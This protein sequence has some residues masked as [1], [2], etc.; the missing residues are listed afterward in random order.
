MYIRDSHGIIYPYICPDVIRTIVK[1]CEY[2]EEE[3]V[4]SF[5]DDKSILDEL[6]EL[7]T[8]MV[9][10]LLS[11]YKDKPSFYKLIKKELI[12]RGEY[13]NKIYKLRKEIVEIELEKGDRNDKYQRRRKIK[14]KES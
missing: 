10:E 5:C 9:H 13:K 3:K 1:D 11:K 8:Y 7:P 2:T 4:D 14:C 6:D 12:C